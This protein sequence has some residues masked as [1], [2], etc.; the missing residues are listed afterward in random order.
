MSADDDFPR[1]FTQTTGIIITAPT[2]TFPAVPGIAWVLTDIEALGYEYQSG[3]GG[4]GSVVTTSLNNSGPTG[5]VA[6]PSGSPIPVGSNG[7]WSWHGKA[8][9]PVGVALTITM[10]VAPNYEVCLTATAYPV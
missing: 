9:G 2:I 3:T 7:E 1:G 8:P 4:L 6:I 10:A 5:L